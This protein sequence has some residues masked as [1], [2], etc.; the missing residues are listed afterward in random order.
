MYSLL[1]MTKAGHQVTYLYSLGIGY[2]D[3]HLLS[4]Q[5]PEVLLE[6]RPEV[7]GE[8]GGWDPR[9]CFPPNPE[10][11]AQQASS[12]PC[13]QFT[14]ISQRLLR[15]YHTDIDELFAEIDHCLAINRSVL[16]QLDGQ[17]GRKLTEDDWQKI[18]AQVGPPK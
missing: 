13:S 3:V 12:P 10:N 11:R 18:Q 16:Q 6:G 9:R 1:T 17:C 8:K 14:E 4:R 5:P 2:L 15:S 7:V